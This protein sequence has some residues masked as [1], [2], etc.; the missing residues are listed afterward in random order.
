MVRRSNLCGYVT[1]YFDRTWKQARIYQEETCLITS[2]FF[3]GVLCFTQ[4]PA[5]WLV[6]C[7][8]TVTQCGDW[9][10]VESKSACS[11]VQLMGRSSCGTLRRSHHVS[12]H[13]TLIEVSVMSCLHCSVIDDVFLSLISLF[14]VV[15]IMVFPHQLISIGVIQLI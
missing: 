7:R 3:I 11:P 13:L 1:S 4:T 5:C 8:V 9:L 12:A 14:P 15:Q 10:T 6:R 2:V